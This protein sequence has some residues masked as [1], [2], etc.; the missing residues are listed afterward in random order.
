MFWKRKQAVALPVTGG[1][2]PASA[3]ADPAGMVPV[4]GAEKLPGPREIPELVA[5]HLVV[6][7]KKDPDQVWKLKAVMRRLPS[8]GKKAFEVRIFD[9]GVVLKRKIRVKDWT[10]LDAYPELVLYEGWADPDSRRVELQERTSTQ[11]PG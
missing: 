8:R 9:E 6:V 2:L 7:M 5:R 3:G 4:T 10:T 11:E 1:T